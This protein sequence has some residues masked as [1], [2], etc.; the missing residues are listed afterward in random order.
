MVAFVWAVAGAPAYAGRSCEEAQTLSVQ[1]VER[2][3]NLAVKTLRA[4]DASGAKVV[5]MARAGQDLSKYGIH[6]SHLGFVYQQPDGEGGHV[7]RVFHKLNQCGTAESAIYRQG[8]GDFFLDD[9]WQYEAAWVV[10]TPEVQQRML[11]L[12][13]D[14]KRAT[15]LHNPSY[16]MVSYPWS[17][18]YQQSNQWAIETLALAMTAGNTDAVSNRKQAQ[19]WLQRN[20][21][22]PSTL[23][24]NAFTRLGARLTKANVAFDD[25]PD[26]KRFSDRI[27]TVT[28]DSVFDWMPRAGFTQLPLSTLR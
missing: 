7:W 26:E 4:L 5:V 19:D 16:S 3:L 13:T 6:Y 27:E 25:H 28:V 23:N 11:V 1:T 21:Y 14:E 9:L 8:L 22:K 10:P 2:S 24:I 18:K 17:Q 15:Q 12:L 20:A